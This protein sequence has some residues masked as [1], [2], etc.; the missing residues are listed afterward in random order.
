MP[1]LRKD[2]VMDRWVII[3]PE[4]SNRPV[5]VIESSIKENHKF[6]PFAPGNEHMTPPEIYAIR[7]NNTEPNSPE[8][9]LRVIPNKYPALQVEEE[10]NRKGDGMYDMM[11]GVGAH[12]VIIETP[13]PQ[14]RLT[15]LDKTTIQDIFKTYKERILD[16]KK[17]I[18]LKYAIIFKNHGFAAG[19]TLSHAHS[20]LIAT[21]IIPRNVVEELQGAASYFKLKERCIFCDI[22]QQERK[23]KSRLVFEEDYFLVLEPFAPRFPFETWILPKKHCSHFEKITNEELLH[24]AISLKTTLLKINKAL[25]SP[26]YNFVIHTAPLQQ[27]ELSYY[28]WHIEIMPKITSTAGFEWG[29]GF[30]INTTSPEEAASY[31]RDIAV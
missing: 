8:W 25:Q 20:Q 31:L 30:Y 22:I 23:D 26:A 10:L 19:A 11:S 28:H 14:Q 5:E 18:R 9:T 21:P 29:T 6:S 17:D 27:E 13:D 4:R 16:L 7:P 1:E 24:I 3:S 2:P 15:D 12:E